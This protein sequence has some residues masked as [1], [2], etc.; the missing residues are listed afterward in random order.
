MYLKQVEQLVMLQKIDDEIIVLDEELSGAPKE[1]EVL[2]TEQA[3]LAE[4]GNQIQE[5]IDFLKAQQSRLENEIEDD[6]LKLKKSKS[7]LMQVGNTKEYHAMMREMDNLEKLNRLRDEDKLAVAEELGR[8]TEAINDLGEKSKAVAA[9]LAKAK[10]NLDSRVKVAK[11]R[12]AQLDEARKT[13]GK[14]VP[15]PILSRYEFIRSR[16]HNPVIVHVA[17]GVCSG[18]NISIPPQAFIE[19]QKGQQIL[20]C[21]NCQRLIYWLEHFPNDAAEP[22]PAKIPAAAASASAAAE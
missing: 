7:K 4:A 8:Q 9:Q 17:A 6:S 5:K 1:I 3:R 20:S 2:E 10:S 19:L 12:L 18:C 14:T 22:I 11:K 15:K 16:L 13:A 21:P